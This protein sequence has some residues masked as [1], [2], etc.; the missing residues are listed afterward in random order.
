MSGSFVITVRKGCS[1]G[2]E[3]NAMGIFS[4]V[5]KTSTDMEEQIEDRYVSMFQETVGMSP[6]QAK[7]ASAILLKRQKKNL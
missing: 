6:S 3:G 4:K 5:L 2:K 1:T 7:S